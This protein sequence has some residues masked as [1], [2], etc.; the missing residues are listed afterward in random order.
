[1]CDMVRKEILDDDLTMTKIGWVYHF[2]SIPN[3][4]DCE[5]TNSWIKKTYEGLYG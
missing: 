1:M 5:V 4:K 2:N 3:Q